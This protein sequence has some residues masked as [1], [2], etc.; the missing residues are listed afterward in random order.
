[1]TSQVGRARI[2]MSEHKEA[3]A[4]NQRVWY[5]NWSLPRGSPFWF[6]FPMAQ[7]A[8]G[9][10][11]STANLVFA[12]SCSSQAYICSLSG[13]HNLLPLCITKGARSRANT[14]TS[15]IDMSITCI[16]WPIWLG[17]LPHIQPTPCCILLPLKQKQS[18]RV[19][20]NLKE[21]QLENEIT[22]TEM[23]LLMTLG[24]LK[25]VF[26]HYQK[27]RSL[28]VKSHKNMLDS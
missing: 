23:R 5:K 20:N 26:T 24:L 1:M 17:L 25:L 18:T 6:A 11:N 19:N 21:V 3:E 13:N 9:Q 16:K 2:L 28:P 22:K 14:K 4:P 7:K 27:N 10:E 15:L 8:T 12:H